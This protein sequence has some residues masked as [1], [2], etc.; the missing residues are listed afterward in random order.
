M[1][2]GR[3]GDQA[4]GPTV[5]G[6][7]LY[8][9]N[10]AATRHGKFNIKRFWGHGSTSFT[11]ETTP[12]C[13]HVPYLIHWPCGSWDTACTVLLEAVTLLQVQEVTVI[14]VD[15]QNLSS[16]CCSIEH[17]LNIWINSFKAFLRYHSWSKLKGHYYFYYFVHAINKRSMS[18]LM[19]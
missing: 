8:L 12:T 16:S 5:G 6:W 15:H 13:F 17:L 9:L 7:L 3:D 14:F 18:L 4:T 10:T 2:Q 11:P 1:V 19:Q